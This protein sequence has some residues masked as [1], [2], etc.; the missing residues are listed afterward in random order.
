[1]APPWSRFGK[2]CHFGGQSRFFLLKW[3]L[4][5]GHPIDM[6]M[7]PL[8]SHFG[9]TFFFQCMILCLLLERKFS[10]GNH[11]LDFQ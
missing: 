8:W 7:A 9:S 4:K 1:M 11:D 2:R 3:Y 6:K 5:G 10:A